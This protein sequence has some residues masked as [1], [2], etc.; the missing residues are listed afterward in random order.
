[1]LEILI[2]P[3][4]FSLTQ[5]QT[6]NDVGNLRIVCDALV[7]SKRPFSFYKTKNIIV[8]YKRY[9]N[10]LGTIPQCRASIILIEFLKQTRLLSEK[11]IE[12]GGNPCQI[13]PCDGCPDVQD[14]IINSYPV[15]LISSEVDCELFPRQNTASRVTPANFSNSILYDLLKTSNSEQLIIERIGTVWDKLLNHSQDFLRTGVTIWFEYRHDSLFDFSSAVIEI[16]K[17]LEIELVRLVDNFLMFEDVANIVEAYNLAELE[18]PAGQRASIFKTL[19]YHFRRDH[20][21]VT[22][23]SFNYLFNINKISSNVLDCKWKEYLSLH[24]NYA[25]LTNTQFRTKLKRITFNFRNRGA[26]IE[27]INYSSCSELLDLV[28]GVPGSASPGM[29]SFCVS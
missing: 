11:D 10:T 22:L 8:S 12:K 24:T 15:H 6:P 21:K 26:H 2:D 7:G 17:T 9:I 20:S 27:S 14:V 1:V 23:G 3:H 5:L 18:T 13:P 28:L 16:S 19:L 25:H 4:I 29:L